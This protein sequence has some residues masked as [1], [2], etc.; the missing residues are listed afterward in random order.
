MLGL[1][2]KETQRPGTFQGYETETRHSTRLIHDPQVACSWIE[3]TAS[4]DP[5][6]LRG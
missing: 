3:P 4:L 2:E 6:L 1:W 5:E